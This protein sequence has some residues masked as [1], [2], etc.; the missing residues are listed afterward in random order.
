MLA[1]TVH[2]AQVSTLEIAL[3]LQ[4]RT[5][6]LWARLLSLK[7][8]VKVVRAVGI[9]G[10]SFFGVALAHWGRIGLGA[11]SVRQ[12]V[13]GFFSFGLQCIPIVN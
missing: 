10:T 13:E 6:P 11:G 3:K 12:I 4:G 5:I 7:L 9:I 2:L 8:W 1:L